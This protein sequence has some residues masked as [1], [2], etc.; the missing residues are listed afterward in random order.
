[1]EPSLY[2]T[3]DE[4]V[5]PGDIV[6]LGPSLR[7]L[8]EVVHVGSQTVGK[9]EVSA[10]LHGVPGSSPPPKDLVEGKK[11]TKLVV[12]ATLTWAVLLTRGCD[13][14]KRR[15]QEVKDKMSKDR[16]GKPGKPHTEESK[17]KIAEAHTGKRHTEEA[18]KKMSLAKLGKSR[19]DLVANMANANRGKKR[20]KELVDR[21]NR[22]ISI[23][24]NLRDDIIQ[25]LTT[26]Q[27]AKIGEII[28]AMKYI[29]NDIKRHFI[30]NALRSL[31][32]EKII[33]K[34]KLG[35]YNHYTITK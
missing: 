28:K 32:K 2:K 8:K 19:T 7:A 17:A 13:I 25:F 33:E 4:K 12:P 35:K 24:P 27:V 3:P 5:R 14:D 18:K 10:V 21:I 6:R 34:R 1:M 23:Y 29:Y 26:I 11:D 30:D 15:T 20:P 31:I 16:K 9:G 22:M